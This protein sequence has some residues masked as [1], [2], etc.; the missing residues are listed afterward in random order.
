MPWFVKIEEGIVD[1]PTFDQ[2]VPAHLSFV[3]DLIKT[4]HHAQTGY[5]KQKGGGM[6]LFEA[7]SMEEAMA[8]VA[9]DPLVKNNCVHYKLHEWHVVM[10]D[11]MGMEQCNVLESN[12]LDTNHGLEAQYST[13]N[14]KRS[15]S[16]AV[17]SR[18]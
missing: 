10:G 11:P 15:T 8:I 16:V 4:G 1:K 3:E 17:E 13:K 2:Y 14:L 7:G 18:G 12:I 5:W 9:R 6:L